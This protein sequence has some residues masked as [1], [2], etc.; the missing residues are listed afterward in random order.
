MM[1][2]GSTHVTK[3]GVKGLSLNTG[4]EPENKNSY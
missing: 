4:M 2:Y 3:V 1:L